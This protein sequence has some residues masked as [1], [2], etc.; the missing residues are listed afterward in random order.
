MHIIVGGLSHKTAPVEVRE[1]ICFPPSEVSEAINA[2]KL[3]KSINEGVLLSTCNRTEVYIVATI[4]DK[5]IKNIIDFLSKKR[6]L[7]LEQLKK[8]LY[9][10][11]SVEAVHHLFRVAASLDSMMLGEAQILGQVK[12]AYNLSFEAEGT[13]IILNRLFREA[14]KVGKRVRTETEIGESAV[15]VSF[16]A[17]ELAKKVFEDLSGRKVMI[18]GAGETGE[19]TVK[20]LLSSGAKSVLV[21]N[22]TYE[23][24]VKL[25]KKFQGEAVKFDERFTYMRM[26]DIVISSTGAPA[27]IFEKKDAIKLMHERKNRPVFLID[28][29]VPRDIAP[30]VGRLYNVFLYD[31]DDLETVV[32]ANLEEREKEARKAEMILEKEVEEF[33]A[34]INSLEVVPTITALKKEAEII[35]TEETAKILRRLKISKRDKNAINALT[36]VIVNRLLHKPIVEVKACSNRKDGYIYI[37]TLRHLFGLEAEKRKDKILNKKK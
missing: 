33:I 24:A 15:S 2:L 6:H 21:S 19:L 13:S 29:A 1:K 35:R 20:H 28:I 4:L 22:R 27:H 23:R 12:E 25:A 30:E 3:Y 17:V 10:Y 26:A 18:I 8:Y 34:W 11:D 32:K 31:I 7:K 5:G 16:A 36:S 9:F 37:D 14:L